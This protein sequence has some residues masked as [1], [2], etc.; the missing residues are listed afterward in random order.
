MGD[1]GSGAYPARPS[2]LFQSVF[3]LNRHIF[4]DL[5]V[6]INPELRRLAGT[7]TVHFRAREAT[8]E[9]RLD[10]VSGLQVKR[11]SQNNHQIRFSQADG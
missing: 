8:N 5:E 11:V 6:K 2:F 9:L 10:L 1:W 3:R 4:Y 7:N